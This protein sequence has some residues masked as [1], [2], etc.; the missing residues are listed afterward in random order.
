MSSVQAKQIASRVMKFLKYCCE[1]DDDELSEDFVD[2]CLGSPNLFIGNNWGL[3]SSVQINYLQSIHDMMDFRKSQGVADNVLRNF[4]VTEVY[5]SRGKRNLSKRKMAE[6]S[7]HLDIDNL[8]ETNSWATFAELQTVVP[9]H[10]PRYNDFPTLCKTGELTKVT[11]K[12][13]TFATRFLPV[14]LLFK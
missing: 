3:S 7:K 11:S 12:S 1:D 14:Y 2:Y 6:W 8:Q 13:L 4:A 9:F 10:L 5:V